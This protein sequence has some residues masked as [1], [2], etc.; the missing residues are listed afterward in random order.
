MTS[1][2]FNE[3]K[4]QAIEEM[5]IFDRLPSAIREALNGANGSVRASSALNA[6]FRG[7]SEEAII[8][9]INRSKK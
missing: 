8:E 5:E 3:R 9:V 7:V 1:P 2:R 4:R 6:L